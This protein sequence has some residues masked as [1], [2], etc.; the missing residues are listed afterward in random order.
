MWYIILFLKGGKR[1]LGFGLPLCNGMG[2]V[3]VRTGTVEGF[4]RFEVGVPE[5]YLQC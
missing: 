3:R 4:R 5:E 1:G 2:V